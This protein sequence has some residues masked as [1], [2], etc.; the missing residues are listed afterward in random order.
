MIGPELDG[1]TYVRDLRT[2]SSVYFYD[3]TTVL[4]LAV[5][6]PIPCSPLAS[7]ASPAVGDPAFQSRCCRAWGCRRFQN[8]DRRRPTKAKRRRTG[9]N[10]MKRHRR[11][12]D[13]LVGTW[14]SR[15]FVDPGALGRRDEMPVDSAWLTDAGRRIGWDSEPLKFKVQTH[16]S[17]SLP[18]STQ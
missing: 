15:A 13:F 18:W 6:A 10:K 14:L 8:P 9:S 1:C 5:V 17:W 2:E 4:E 3:P 11:S 12:S 16:N 7:A